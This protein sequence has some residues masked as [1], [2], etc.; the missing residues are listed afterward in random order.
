MC[1][2]IYIYI[3]SK[4]SVCNCVILHVYFHARIF[5]CLR[6][7][8]P[9]AQDARLSAV[10]SWHTSVA[11]GVGRNDW[12][13][14]STLTFVVWSVKMKVRCLLCVCLTSA[15]LHP[16]NCVSVCFVC[17]PAPFKC[18][19][20][21]PRVHDAFQVAAM[22]LISYSCVEGHFQFKEAQNVGSKN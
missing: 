15:S 5:V 12:N 21:C 16:K 14:A 4:L 17:L 13:L 22:H 7:L 3:T 8:M 1:V 18:P 9:R 19:L 6:F 2:V 10:C 11:I 20:S